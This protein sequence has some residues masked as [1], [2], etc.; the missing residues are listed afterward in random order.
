MK[1][2]ARREE[3]LRL[4]DE[5]GE[6]TVEDLAERFDASRETIRRDLSDLDTGGHIRKFYGGARAL[7]FKDSSLYESEFDARMKERKAEKAAIARQAASLFAEGSVLF[8]DT[9]S[10]TIAFAEALA[11][12]RNMTVITNSPQIARILAQAEMRHRVYLVGGEVAAEGRETLGAMAVAQIAYFK[13]E[14]VV[15]TVGAITTSALMDYDLR[16]TE[17]A[18]A[19]IAQAQSVT[20]LADHDKLGRP[21]VFEV[22]VLKEVTR[23]VT[24]SPP[25]LEMATALAAA[26]VDVILARSAAS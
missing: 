11:R 1:P 17:M 21:A 7:I 14:H 23:L 3:I 8:I 2:A 13:A 22:A 19:M 10:T 4:L 20:V 26:G 16:E 5:T 18:R 9:G 6:V 25:T 12:R 24:D 15:L